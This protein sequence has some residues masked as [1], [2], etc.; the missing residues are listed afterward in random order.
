MSAGRPQILPLAMFSLG[1]SKFEGGGDNA[2]ERERSGSRSKSSSFSIP[3]LF[4][5]SGGD[6]A[7]LTRKS[8]SSSL[9]ESLKGLGDNIKRGASKWGEVIGLPGTIDRREKQILLSTMSTLLDNLRLQCPL[10]HAGVIVAYSTETMYP[11]SRSGIHLTWFRTGGHGSSHF[12]QV[13]KGFRPFYSPS[14]DD[15]GHRICLQCQDTFGE[16]YSRYIESDSPIIADKLLTGMTESAIKCGYFTTH[17]VRNLSVGTVEKLDLEGEPTVK[18]AGDEGGSLTFEASMKPESAEE[19]MTERTSSALYEEGDKYLL[20]DGV[21]TAH[22]SDKGL[23]LGSQRPVGPVRAGETGADIEVDGVRV[24]PSEDITV[25]CSSPCAAVVSVPLEYILKEPEAEKEE[26]EGEGAPSWRAVAPWGRENLAFD[27]DT[28]VVAPTLVAAEEA[29]AGDIA[30]EDKEGGEEEP[31]T[32]AETASTKK[33]TMSETLEEFLGSLDKGDPTAKICLVFDDRVTRDA[34][35]LLVRGMVCGGGYSGGDAESTKDEEERQEERKR[36]HLLT[37]PWMDES[38]GEA[39]PDAVSQVSAA[40]IEMGDR[41]N[42]LELENVVLKKERIDLTMRLLALES[43]G[44]GAGGTA[45]NCTTTTPNESQLSGPTPAPIADLTSLSSNV[46]ELYAQMM[47]HKTS[48]EKAVEKARETEQRAAALSVELEKSQERCQS[49]TSGHQ[50]VEEQLSSMREE[51]KAMCDK[52]ADIKRQLAAERETGQGQQAQVGALRKEVADLQAKN[53]D[54]AAEATSLQQVAQ[55]RDGEIA[56]LNSEMKEQV[57]VVEAKEIL[58]AQLEAQVMAG[59]KT[60]MQQET[61]IGVLQTNLKKMTAAAEGRDKAEDDAKRAHLNADK[62]QAQANVE[63]KR[64]EGLAKELKRLVKENNLAIQE[65]E[66]ALSRKSE[67]NNMLYEKVQLYEG[68]AEGS[69]ASND[70]GDVG[71][72]LGITA[73]ADSV[74]RFTSGAMEQ[75]GSFGRRGSGSKQGALK[76]SVSPSSSSVSLNES[77]NN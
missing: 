52:V 28:G 65:F 57:A 18:E 39:V 19:L 9:R 13:Q 58:R 15:I 73:A 26:V 70:G 44:G 35:V 41:L 60:K 6:D 1:S 55:E 48:R 34:F 11:L 77:P 59:L 66:R 50:K 64:G 16:G 14:C 10:S 61:E 17:K 68:S 54:I 72:G 69:V 5:G 75:L 71:D 47:V 2:E 37:L 74:K 20:L 40:T 56:R 30:T 31:E 27:A 49:L 24:M 62:F 7:A 23:F 67:E 8:R 46:S 3:P 51:M 29:G 22:V 32:D 21:Y 12:K 63:K 53:A 38:T 33:K 25:T 36:R 42:H 45:A 4:G 76:T 43:G